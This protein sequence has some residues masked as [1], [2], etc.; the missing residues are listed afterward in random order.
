MVVLDIKFIFEGMKDV[1]N[2][3]N[4]WDTKWRTDWRGQGHNAFADKIFRD[5]LEPRDVSSIVDLGCGDGPDSIF[6]AKR[7]LRVT[8]VDFSSVALD[9]LQ[10]RAREARVHNLIECVRS[11]IELVDD[12]KLVADAVYTH[13]GIQFFNNEETTQIFDMIARNLQQ[14]GI[15]ALKMK[16]TIDPMSSKGDEVDE[17]VFV[18]DGQL[19]HFFSRDK[20]ERL[21][22]GLNILELAEYTA[23]HPGYDFDQGFIHVVVQKDL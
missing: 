2:Q 3:N 4:L 23:P 15:A 22:R 18:L 8:A 17:G 19:R 14:G 5:Y 13:L 9:R 11:S 6:F 21:V 10:D 20:V 1:P 7:G 12:R 16:S